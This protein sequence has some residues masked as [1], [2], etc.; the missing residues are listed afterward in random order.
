[1]TDEE[2]CEDC[3]ELAKRRGFCDDHMPTV[4]YPQMERVARESDEQFR[5]GGDS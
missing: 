2:Y 3:G 5:S 4:V 1:M